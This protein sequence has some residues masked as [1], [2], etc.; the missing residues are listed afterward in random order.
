MQPHQ[1]LAQIIN[2]KNTETKPKKNNKSKKQQPE[3]KENDEF[4]KTITNSATKLSKD[5]RKRVQ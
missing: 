1:D 3:K 5:K 2:Q 4:E